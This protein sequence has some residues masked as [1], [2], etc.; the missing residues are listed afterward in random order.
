MV[1]ERHEW[2]STNAPLAVKIK[3]ASNGLETEKSSTLPGSEQA[4]HQ[5]VE[6]KDQKPA[7]EQTV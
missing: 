5:S 6:E 1:R 3:E 2:E 4:L 7:S